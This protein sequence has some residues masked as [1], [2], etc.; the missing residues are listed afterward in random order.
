MGVVECVKDVDSSEETERNAARM[1]HLSA[2]ASFFG[3]GPP[4]QVVPNVMQMN[5]PRH[6]NDDS[7]VLRWLR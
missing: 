5:N 3:S 7:Q 4:T 1:A 2:L 6:N